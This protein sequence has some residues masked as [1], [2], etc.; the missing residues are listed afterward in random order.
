MPAQPPDTSVLKPSHRHKQVQSKERM[1]GFIEETQIQT[2]GMPDEGEKS[3]WKTLLEAR[4]WKGY[5]H[6]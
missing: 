2:Q 5:Q 6:F 1:T 3:S 4:L